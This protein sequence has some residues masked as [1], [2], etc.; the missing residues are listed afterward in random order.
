MFQNITPAV[1]TIVIINVIIYIISLLI[2]NAVFLL[3]AYFPL[4]PNFKLFQLFTHIFLFNNFLVLLLFCIPFLSFGPLLERILGTKQFVL[5][6]LTCAFVPYL[7]YSGISFIQYNSLTSSFSFEVVNSIYK[8]SY[9]FTNEVTEL[10]NLQIEERKTLQ[11][12]T[13]P[14]FG[15]EGAIFGFLMAFGLLCP[16]LTIMLLF[17]PIPLKAKYLIPISMG[18]SIYFGYKDILQGNY[19][20]LSY[21]YG[22]VVAFIWIYFFKRKHG[23]IEI[24]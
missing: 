22:A 8:S 9:L 23:I 1:K 2:P 6:F 11:I 18:I 4:S 20:Q 16:N 5:F 17:P 24:Y 14:F 10:R 19:A 13:T 15:Q 3:S 12:L 7:I 21:L